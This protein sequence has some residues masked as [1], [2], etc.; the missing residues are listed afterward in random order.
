[1]GGTQF[2][3]TRST[4]MQDSAS[5]FHGLLSHRYRSPVGGGEPIFIDRDPT[6]FRHILNY[7]RDGVVSHNEKT[8]LRVLEELQR[9]ACFYQLAG[10]IDSLSGSVDTA[11]QNEYNSQSEEKMYTIV[12]DVVERDMERVLKE[13]TE[14]GWDLH[15]WVP[16]ESVPP[17]PAKKKSS[18]GRLS[19]PGSGR[20]ASGGDAA[21][22]GGGLGGA[23]SFRTYHGTFVQVVPAGKVKEMDNLLGMLARA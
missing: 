17:P 15:S 6:H 16:A 5:Y 7:L 2:T 10:L 18:L 22:S 12:H 19:R 20:S 21:G 8:D 11:Q 4:L 1:M 3:T 13:K 23:A 14:D 9:E